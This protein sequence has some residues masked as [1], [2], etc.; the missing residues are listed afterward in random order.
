MATQLFDLLAR[1]EPYWSYRWTALIPGFYRLYVE[2]CDLPIFRTYSTNTVVRASRTFVYAGVSEG[3]TSFSMSFFEDQE[4]RTLDFLRTWNSEIQDQ[5]TG[6]YYLPYNYKRDMQ[7]DLQ[8][9]EGNVI[10]TIKLLGCFPANVSPYP[11]QSATAE[12]VIV[13]ATFSADGISAE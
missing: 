7:V 4:L 11:L 12:R 8:S 13:Q 3:A 6:E 10:K 2:A 5:E 9:I 1:Q